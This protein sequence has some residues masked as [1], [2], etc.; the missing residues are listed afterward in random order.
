M[1]NDI[2]ESLVDATESETLRMRGNSLHGN[3]ETLEAP[4]STDAGRSEKAQG[5]TSDMHASRESDGPIIPKKPG[6]QGRLAGCGA[7]G[8]K[9][10][11][12]GKRI[13]SGGVGEG[14]RSGVRRENGGPV[15]PEDFLLGH[16]PQGVALAG[17]MPDPSGNGVKDFQPR[18]RSVCVTVRPFGTNAQQKSLTALP[19]G[20]WKERSRQPEARIRTLFF[21]ASQVENA[22]LR[23]RSHHA[24]A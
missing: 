9:G 16:N 8:G 15:G 11:D 12:Q 18:N 1:R 21:I 3:R 20:A 7:C 24:G 10:I 14:L 6:E 4:S 19:F 22:G 2:R 17:R 5:H 13:A 23:G